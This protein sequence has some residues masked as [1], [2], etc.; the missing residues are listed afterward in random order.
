MVERAFSVN[1]YY[2]RPMR[3]AKSNMEKLN[4]CQV[5]NVVC[6]GSRLRI[7]MVKLDPS[8]AAV[9]P[10]PFKD[11]THPTPESV[12]CVLFVLLLRKPPALPVEVSR[13]KAL[14]SS[15]ERSERIGRILP[16]PSNTK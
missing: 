8:G 9:I 12:G 16:I 14:A 4:F 13:K 10:A 5:S 2:S 11:N 6:D 1:M 3:L 15:I 7:V